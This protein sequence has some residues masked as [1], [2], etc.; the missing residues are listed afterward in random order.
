MTAREKIGLLLKGVKSEEIK[1]LEEQE[2]QEEE[3]KN[4]EQKNQEQKDQEQKNQEQKNQEQKEQNQKE[5]EDQNNKPSE[6]QSIIEAIAQLSETVETLQNKIASNNIN[7]NT[8]QGHK[9][10]TVEEL[11]NSIF[12]IRKEEK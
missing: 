7:N 1:E 11:A 10:R 3:Q 4:Q 2:K 8:Q 12:N 9:D 5:Q 6:N